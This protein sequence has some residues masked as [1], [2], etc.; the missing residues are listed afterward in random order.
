MCLH[1]AVSRPHGDAMLKTKIRIKH[2]TIRQLVSSD[3]DRA[4]GG[5]AIGTVA[6]APISAKC[7]APTPTVG[8]TTHS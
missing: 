1:R 2:E 3:L 4:I 7:P 5:T 6:P 8:C